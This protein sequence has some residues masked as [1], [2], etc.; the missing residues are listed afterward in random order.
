MNYI[1][2][3]MVPLGSFQVHYLL[4]FNF[5]L[6]FH[7]CIV[8]YSLVYYVC[9]HFSVKIS[10][11]IFEVTLSGLGHFKIPLNLHSNVKSLEHLV[12]DSCKVTETTE[13]NIH[14]LFCY[15]ISYRL[16]ILLS[17]SFLGGIGKYRMLTLPDVHLYV[18][19]R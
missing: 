10:Y 7:F 8:P 1:S 12:F 14:A 17:L 18:L 16:W 19:L 15:S 2:L 3:L 11:N 5:I 9:S 13:S 4:R 6:P